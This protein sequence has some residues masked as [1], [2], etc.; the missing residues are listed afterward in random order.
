MPRNDEHL[1]SWTHVIEPHAR[2]FDLKLKEVWR[3]RDLIGLL[4]HRDFVAQYKQT[5]L[6]PAWHLI[7]PLLVTIMFT[8]VFGRIAGILQ[9]IMT[10]EAF[11]E[12]VDRLNSHG[13]QVV[14][15]HYDAA[16]YRI[17]DFI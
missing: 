2:A 4:V 6:G 11:R 7:Q 1:Q 14:C 10:P 15:D 9:T 16:A 17:D 12:I 3:Y 8:I 5:I 13:Y